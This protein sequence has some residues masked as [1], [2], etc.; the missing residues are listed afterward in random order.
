MGTR[1][2]TVCLWIQVQKN[3]ATGAAT[4]RIM[5]FAPNP[6]RPLKQPPKRP[7]SLALSAFITKNSHP[8]G[9]SR[10][11]W[12]TLILSLKLN[13]YKKWYDDSLTILI[14]WARSSNIKWKYVGFS[15][16][17]GWHVSL[18]VLTLMGGAGSL[19]RSSPSKVNL[20]LFCAPSLNEE[21]KDVH[22]LK[23][24]SRRHCFS[25]E[26]CHKRMR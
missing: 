4:F 19:Q 26:W 9:N 25:N 16:I 2:R 17:S 8:A 1:A 18:L 24:F 3:G 6:L 5:P 21:A 23:L 13:Q 14:K 22:S 15:T 10:R 11:T 12:Y 7:T 20:P